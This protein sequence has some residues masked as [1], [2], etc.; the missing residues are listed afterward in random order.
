[1]LTLS[2]LSDYAIVLMTC[3]ATQDGYRASARTLA[4]GTRIPLPTV[5]RLL[6][7]LAAGGTLQSIQGRG[8]GY[9]LKRVPSEVPVTEVIEN[10]EG[11]IA[12]TQCSRD[13]GACQIEN[14]CQVRR[15]WQFI[16]GAFRQS[17]AHVSLADLAGPAPPRVAIGPLHSADVGT[18]RAPRRIPRA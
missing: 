14:S 17:L 10:V 2:R 9:R 4:E 1:V 11:P 16:N 5:V 18:R 15:H 12:L 6:K 3:L 13:S 8:G 7:L